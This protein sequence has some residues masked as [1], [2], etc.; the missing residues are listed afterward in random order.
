MTC[1]SQLDASIDAYNA[2]QLC[3]HIFVPICNFSVTLESLETITLENDSSLFGLP[4]A[5]SVILGE[6]GARRRVLMWLEVRIRNVLAIMGHNAVGDITRGLSVR[7]LTI[8]LGSISTN[9][10]GRH[11]QNRLHCKAG[12]NKSVALRLVGAGALRRN[13]LLKDKWNLLGALH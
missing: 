11:T 8:A 4:V 1:F 3:M 10:T 7:Q 2:T 6:R 13:I 12:S 5:G 9:N